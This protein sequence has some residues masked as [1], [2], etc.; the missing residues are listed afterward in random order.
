MAKAKSVK[1]G[2]DPQVYKQNELD[3]MIELIKA[4]DWKSTNLSK[5]LN[6]DM[7]T[8]ADWKKREDVQEAYRLTVLKFVKRRQDP[9]KV[10]SEL[11][12]DSDPDAPLI[13]N[14]YYT[15]L[16]DS[17]LDELIKAKAGKTG[18]T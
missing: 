18:F 12:F 2:K 8:V 17:Q 4:G 3:L 6:L 14:N 15:N 16:S 10:L 13:Q 7:N 5:I 11:G 9:E 1:S